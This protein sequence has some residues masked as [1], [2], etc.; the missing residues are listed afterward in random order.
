MLSVRALCGSFCLGSFLVGQSASQTPEAPRVQAATAPVTP[1]AVHLEAVAYDPAR[2][3]LVL[4]GGGKPTAGG[5]FTFPG[6]TWEW[7]GTRWEVAVDSAA[8]PGPRTAAAMAYDATGRRVILFGGIRESSTGAP[9]QMLCDFWGYDGGWTRI[10]EGPCVTG[11]PAGASLVLDGEASLLLIDG[12]PNPPADTSGVPMRIW[13]RTADRWV[14]ADSAGP[15]RYG[16]GAVAFDEA[17]RVLVVPVF[18]GPDAG[19]WEWDGRRWSSHAP[20]GPLRGA[21]FPWSMT[22]AHVR[23]FSSAA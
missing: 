13:R 3:R 19:V 7:D 17:R 1:P 20:A 21:D 14:L 16:L 11:R 12:I 2:E 6:E 10:D 9:A 8:G 22:G 15:R 18:E 4:F 5:P 23:P